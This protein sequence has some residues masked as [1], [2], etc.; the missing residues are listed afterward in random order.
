MRYARAISALAIASALFLSGCA[1][2]SDADAADANTAAAPEFNKADVTFAQGMIPHHRQAIAMAQL[3]EGRASDPAVEQ[4]A[5][6]I[7]AAQSPEIRM[8]QGWLRSWNKP[9][10]SNVDGGSA[11]MGHGGSTKGM[12][13]MMPISDMRQLRSVKGAAFD[14]AFL[15][16]MIK[17]HKGAIEMAHTEEQQGT[18]PQA[19]G[20]AKKIQHAQSAEI[21]N[22][23][24]MLGD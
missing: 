22:M 10:N 8:M 11:P 3:A 1:A 17:H 15:S 18:N 5:H 6:K 16:M 12:S 4:L 21:D 24:G 19:V 7:E 9:M 2:N 20:L 23:T 14:E 13:G